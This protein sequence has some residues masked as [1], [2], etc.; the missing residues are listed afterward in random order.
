MSMDF[1]LA[2]AR[3]TALTKQKSVVLDGRVVARALPLSMCRYPA[4]TRVGLNV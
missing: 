3:F 4:A 1:A 2:Y